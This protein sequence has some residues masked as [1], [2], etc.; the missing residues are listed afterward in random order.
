V[1]DH[2]PGVAHPS[3]PPLTTSEAPI[4]DLAN[5]CRLTCTLSPSSL[6]DRKRDIAE[7]LRRHPP[8]ITTVPEGRRLTF[9]A[10]AKIEHELRQL[11][12]LE[13]DCCAF[14]AMRLNTDADSVS[15][16]VTGPPETQDQL[17]DISRHQLSA[18]PAADVRLDVGRDG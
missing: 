2:H 12:A 18:L 13:A 1:S 9:V 10:G 14:L 8:V 6:A 16:T 7:L 17:I 11:I 4:T 5:S 15:L 3:R